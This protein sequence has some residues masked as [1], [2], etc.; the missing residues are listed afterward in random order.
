MTVNKADPVHQPFMKGDPV[1]MIYAS[2]VNEDWKRL[3][4]LLEHAKSKR[5]D[6]VILTKLLGNPLTI[7]EQ[8]AYQHAYRFVEEDFEKYRPFSDIQQFIESFAYDDSSDI[9]TK[10]GRTILRLIERG[11]EVIKAR[12]KQFKLVTQH[13][14]LPLVIIPGQFENLDMIR[15]I[16]E[17][18]A[19]RYLNLT[20]LDIK[21]IRLLG[22]G[23]QVT[24][25]QNTPLC[26]QNRDYVEGTEQ[27]HEELREILSQRIDVLIS[28]TPI[29]HYADNA[30]EEKNVRRY[31]NDYL[32]GKTILTAQALPKNPMTSR[33]TATD[34]TLIKGG[35]FSKSGHFWEI[36][37][38]NYGVVEKRLIQI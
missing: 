13:F 26:F 24:L 30:F 34:A 22:I 28:Y 4:K 15:S 10:S 38:N 9:V 7:E 16:D 3:Q 32:P 19:G 23:G 11:R 31:M 2:N 8:S 17:E 35:Y 18:F 20:T 6:L 29:R 14:N 36:V 37:A 5:A 21:N 25:E 12:I 33:V 1:K 27:S